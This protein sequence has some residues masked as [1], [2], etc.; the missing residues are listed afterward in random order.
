MTSGAQVEG[1]VA[2]G[3]EA[4]ATTFSAVATASARE[5]AQLAVYHQDKKVVDLW[6]GSQTSGN[7]ISPVFSV[8]KGVAFLVAAVLVRQGALDLERAVHD[9]W[10]QFVGDGKET[11]TVKQLFSHQAGLIG[12]DEGF[13]LLE[14]A[15]DSEIASRLAT[16]RP[17]WMPGTAYGYHALVAGALANEV[18]KRATGSSIQ[19]IYS[20]TI[21]RPYDID[22]YFGVPASVE[23]RYTP[24]MPAAEQPQFELPPL[25]SIAFNLHGAEPT[26]LTV[27]GNSAAVH[28]K[29][30]TSAGGTGSA[31]GLARLYSAISY[32]LDGLPALLDQD[33]LNTFTALQTSGQ[34]VV[35]GT[36]DHFAV[37]FERVHTIFDSAS[38]NAFGHQGASGSLAFFDPAHEFSYAYVRRQMGYPGAENQPLIDSIVESITGLR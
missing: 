17:Y 6:F 8:G 10:P 29:G 27:F 2:A 18:V 12:V 13:S 11:L 21:Q 33:T 37:G 23:N 7:S 25:M 22:F 4:V 16:Q 24:A 19:E 26:D 14:L 32:G 30:P 1:S 15:D 34:D 9:Y 36:F 38:E 20:E 5:G 31:R 35:T 3:F 28:Q